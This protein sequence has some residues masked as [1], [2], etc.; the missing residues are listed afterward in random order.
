MSCHVAGMTDGDGWP[1]MTDFIV[2]IGLV[3][4]IE[5]A[6][7]ALFPRAAFSLIEVASRTP[8]DTLRI[9]GVVAALV[10]LL[11]VWLARG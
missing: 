9:G 10:G 4:V 2:A 1:A 7:W 6:L 5:G 11:I 8:P 3:L